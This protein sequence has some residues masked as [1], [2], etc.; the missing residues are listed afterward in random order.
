MMH[1]STTSPKTRFVVVSQHVSGSLVLNTEY[2]LGSTSHHGGGQT[3]CRQC[4]SILDFAQAHEYQRVSVINAVAR[5]ADVSFCVWSFPTR[6]RDSRHFSRDLCR[7]RRSA[8]ECLWRP[9]VCRAV[10]VRPVFPA[11]EDDPFGLS[12]NALHFCPP[13]PTLEPIVLH[14]SRTQRVLD[15]ETRILTTVRA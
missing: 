5:H 4:C 10:C 1:A 15:N 9:K 12:R 7:E 11:C 14:L 6:R 3:P 13:K 2:L 8:G